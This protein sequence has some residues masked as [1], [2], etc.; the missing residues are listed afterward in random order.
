MGGCC[1]RRR[2]VRRTRQGEWSKVSEDEVGVF[3]LSDEDAQWMVEAG[4]A[5]KGEDG[6]LWITDLGQQEIRKLLDKK[7]AESE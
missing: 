6:D 7:A 1:H 3:E 5:A 2:A 4:W